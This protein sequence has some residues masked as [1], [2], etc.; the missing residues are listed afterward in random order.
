MAEVEDG[1]PG[2]E[3]GGERPDVD[4]D[5]REAQEQAD[6]DDGLHGA[7]ATGDREHPNRNNQ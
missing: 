6:G 7:D 4:K 3:R 2:F 1:A 5:L